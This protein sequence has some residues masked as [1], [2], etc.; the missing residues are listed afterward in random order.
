MKRDSY[1]PVGSQ[2]LKA[3]AKVCF[4][5]NSRIVESY[6][7][8]ISIL[9]LCVLDGAVIH[10][11]IGEGQIETKLLLQAKLRYDPMEVDPEEMCLM[12]REN[13]Q[14]RSFSNALFLIKIGKSRCRI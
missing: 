11:A 9:L 4:L 13:P 7:R 10:L 1:L 14:V 12:A 3:V 6:I 8:V 5:S 2:N